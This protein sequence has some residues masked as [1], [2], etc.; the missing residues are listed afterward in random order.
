MNTVAVEQIANAVLYEGYMLYPYRPSADQ[1][2]P[3][4]R[5]RSAV[6]ESLLRARGPGSDSWWMRTECLA[7]A[8]DERSWT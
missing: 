5:L 8:A 3:A 2:P 1:E 7:A 4:I 6:S